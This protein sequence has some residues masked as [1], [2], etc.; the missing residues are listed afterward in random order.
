MVDSTFSP[1]VISLWPNGAPGSE[2]WSQ[3][4]QETYLPLPSIVPQT[5]LPL[6]FDVKIV[7]NIALLRAGSVRAGSLPLY[8]STGSYRQQSVMKTSQSNCRNDSPT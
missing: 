5:Y 3:H 2:H 1:E 7:R 4:E 8:S 6:P